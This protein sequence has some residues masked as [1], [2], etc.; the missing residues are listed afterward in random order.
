MEEI[1]G[2]AAHHFVFFILRYAGEIP[3]DN[4]EGFRPVGFLVRKIRAPDEMVDVDLV[5]QLDADA[6]ELKPPQAML[7]YVFARWTAE[8]LE[9]EQAFGPPDMTVVAHVRCLQEKGD[10]ANLIF[11][12][13]YPQ[14]RKTIEEPG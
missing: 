2:I 1:D 3:F 8:G 13:E 4:R 12:E 9:A 5:T 14:V 10:P 7:A 6:I 11:G